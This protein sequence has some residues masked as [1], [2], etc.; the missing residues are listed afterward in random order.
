M[1]PR[2]AGDHFRNEGEAVAPMFQSKMVS[3]YR[4]ILKA[5]LEMRSAQN[6]RYSLRAF[7]RDLKVAPSR[8]SEILNGK[9]G[10]S[11]KAATGLADQLGYLAE[12]KQY[13]I[14]LVLA[15]HARSQRD[16][17]QARERLARSQENYERYF[18]LKED[19][20]RIIADWYHLAIL[21]LLKLP[22]FK[23]CSKWIAK[24][25]DLTPIQVELAVDR[26]RRVGLLE[27]KTERL[28]PTHNTGWIESDIP[29][30]SI[31]KFHRQ[32]LQ[33]AQ[34]ALS[35]QKNADREYTANLLTVSR[36]RL[37]EAKAAIRKF[38]QSIIEELSATD[39]QDDLY[40]LS[41]QFFSL[42]NRRAL[43]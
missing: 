43:C 37:P 35:L 40:C 7:A 15:A 10:L 16:K 27:A 38:Q 36:K 31:R 5:E 42:T 23:D 8:L 13:F 6:P 22:G 29:S 12:E 1:A 19:A 9:Q 28:L 39:D 2:Q 32:V 18:Q 14:D 30:E 41:I 20:F 24:K 4:A 21:E 3:D 11:A 33:K 17:E 26:L 25:L 34:E